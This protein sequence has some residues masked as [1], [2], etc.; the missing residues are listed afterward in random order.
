MKFHTSF[1]IF[2]LSLEYSHF[3]L[4]LFV[5]F[6]EWGSIL[7]LFFHFTCLQRVFQFFFLLHG[8]NVKSPLC[9]GKNNERNNNTIRYIREQSLLD[10]LLV[11]SYV[12][13]YQKNCI[14]FV[15]NFFLNKFMCFIMIISYFYYNYGFLWQALKKFAFYGKTLNHCYKFLPIGRIFVMSRNIIHFVNKTFYRITALDFC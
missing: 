2:K 13:K 1:S 4:M 3:E 15:I 9:I 14:L 6:D 11:I 12:D 8:F 7:S 10:I 5:Q